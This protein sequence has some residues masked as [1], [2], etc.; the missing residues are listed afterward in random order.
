MSTKWN[1]VRDSGPQ[2]TGMGVIREGGA[3][4]RNLDMMGEIRAQIPS[5]GGVLAQAVMEA[6]NSN[7]KLELRAQNL[8][9]CWVSDMLR[10]HKHG[11]VA[12][13]SASSYRV[14]NMKFRGW[15]LWCVLFVL[16]MGLSS[17]SLDKPIQSPRGKNA[18]E[19]YKQGSSQ[20]E[21]KNYRQAIE[22]FY[23]LKYD[24]P[25]EAAA[26]MADLKIADAHYANK[27][28]A[29]AVEGYEE[30]RKMH[31]A[32][33]YIPYVVY[34]L[35]MCHYHR[36]LSVDR[37]QSETEKA[38]A[39]FQYLLTHFP[40]TPYAY[41]SYQKVQECMKKLSDHEVYVGNFYFR[42]NK[43][44]AAIQRYEAALAK[45]PSVPLEEEVLFQLAEAYQATKE[46]EKA[47]R[48]LQVLSQQ[49]PKGKYAQ[50]AQKLLQGELAAAQPS[51]QPGSGQAQAPLSVASASS[52]PG[53]GSAKA[54]SPGPAPEGEPR[55][56]RAQ[57]EAPK[58][59]PRPA[60]AE[61]SVQETA[62][63][64]GPGSE[65]QGSTPE[66]EG[67]PQVLQARQRIQEGSSEEASG[68]STR[69]EEVSA[70]KQEQPRLPE[71]APAAVA[72]ESK[73][74]DTASGL[75]PTAGTQGTTQ[76][77]GGVEPEPPASR[78][79]P[80]MPPPSERQA[81]GQVAPLAQVKAKPP[82]APAPKTS[83]QE[84]ATGVPDNGGGQRGDRPKGSQGKE[85]SIGFGELRSDK[86]I[87]ITADRMDA[88]QRDNRV[89]FEGNVV[90]QQ[91]ETYLYARRI[92]ADMAPQD[93]GGG[94]RKVVAQDNVKITQND[95][96][97]TCDRAEFDHLRRTIELHGNPKIWQGKDWI[98]GEKVL[99]QLD[100]E[101]MTVVGS[102]EKRVSAVLH[103][104]PQKGEKEEPAAGKE[105]K[106][107]P[108]LSAPFAPAAPTPPLAP[109]QDVAPAPPASPVAKI[110]PAPVSEQPRKEATKRAQEPQA[111]APPQAA[112]VS[113]PSLRAE[114][115]AARIAAQSAPDLKKAS[116]ETSRPKAAAAEKVAGVPSPE[117]VASFVERWCKAWGSRDIDA[118]MAFYSKK[119]RSGALDWNGWRAYKAATFRKARSIEVSTEAL[120]SKKV[121]AR[122]KVSFLQHYRADHHQDR[123]RKELELVNEEGQWKIVAES[124]KP[125]QSGGS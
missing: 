18:D 42:M 37:D 55:T 108:G 110:Q 62:G 38:L 78:T 66:R 9:K 107:R 61:K 109:P 6:A 20:L 84:N 28:Y 92:V 24:F 124:W 91:E 81:P 56:G 48:T 101:K 29:E 53:R 116:A 11:V 89:I 104:K 10:F 75:Q 39:E 15:F 118:Y 115:E 85:E 35:G 113:A 40:D 13:T 83:G 1:L 105:P 60:P 90:A 95:R 31:P 94:I 86:P 57:T 54:A 123:G 106:S 98:D 51:A 70:L 117:P 22:T 119:F 114:E 33:P 111:V 96:V 4:V 2:P 43:Y 121:G 73:P 46:P 7:G 58:Q 47:A 67:K 80:P 59:E 120:E 97:A 23:K 74:A 45:Y 87:N 64:Q 112:A 93:Q 102:E 76:G 82:Q 26:V 52:P 44:P 14:G 30:V 72:Q 3:G 125:L 12:R 19:L 21:Q 32:S 36:S 34:M 103:P 79:P 88:F 71:K 99:V 63:A 122:L 17:C 50:R 100:Q 27:E 77:A 5:W 65:P 16:I 69:E 41:D 68:P 8:T 49:Y 25:S